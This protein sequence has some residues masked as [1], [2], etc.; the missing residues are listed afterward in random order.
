MFGGGARLDT[1]GV[2]GERA[3]GRRAPTKTHLDLQLQWLPRVSWFLRGSYFLSTI[4]LHLHLAGSSMMHAVTRPAVAQDDGPPTFEEP[5]LIKMNNQ[6]TKIGHGMPVRQPLRQ[7][8][9]GKRG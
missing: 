9:E 5:A 3:A 2:L 4:P 7:P 1:L 6:H 8:F